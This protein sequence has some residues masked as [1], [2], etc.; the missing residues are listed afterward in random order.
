[1]SLHSLGNRGGKDYHENVVF[2]CKI[3]V[4]KTVKEMTQAHIEIPYEGTLLHKFSIGKAIRN[5]KNH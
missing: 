1:M 2:F 5:F 3:T 4:V